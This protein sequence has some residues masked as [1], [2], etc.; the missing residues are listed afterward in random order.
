M[1]NYILIYNFDQWVKMMATLGEM[2]PPR[3]C[4]PGSNIATTIELDGAREIKEEE[5]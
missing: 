4:G 1:A 3:D 2:C 5:K